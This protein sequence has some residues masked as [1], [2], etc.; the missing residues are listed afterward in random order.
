MERT[1]LGTGTASVIVIREALSVAGIGLDDIATFD[2]SSCF[3]VPVF[4]ICD[5]L[6]LAT[7]DSRGLTITGG[8]PFFGGP[9]NNYSMHAIAETV[10]EMRDKPGQFGLV[11]ANGGIMSKYSVGVYSTEPADWTPDRSA[12]L[13]D[14]VVGLAKVAVTIAADGPATIET[15]TI[16]YD[17]PRTTGVIAG[18]LD[19]DGSRF[20]ATTEDD[21]LVAPMS[22]GDPLGA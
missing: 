1:D 17:W 8:L 10:A 19:S 22:E 9:G 7:D 2:L 13:Q 20:L 4:N 12:A 6:G 16:R 18:R 3:P 21:D 15:Y 5:G 11:G 14:E